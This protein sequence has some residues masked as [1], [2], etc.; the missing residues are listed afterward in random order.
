[1]YQSQ[2]HGFLHYRYLANH[3]VPHVE[4]A[5]SMTKPQLLDWHRWC[6]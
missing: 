4:A 6:L 3:Y 2:T 1:M 5:A